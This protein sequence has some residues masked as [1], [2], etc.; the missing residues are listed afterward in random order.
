MKDY[1]HSCSLLGCW[2][3]YPLYPNTP[4]KEVWTASSDN[5]ELSRWDLETGELSCAIWPCPEEPIFSRA[6]VRDYI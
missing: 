3:G 1:R 4:F 6:K 2:P 5:G